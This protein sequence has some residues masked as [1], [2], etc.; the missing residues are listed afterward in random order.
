MLSER[1]VVIHYVSILRMFESVHKEK[2]F[3]KS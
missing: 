1:L 2:V 3:S